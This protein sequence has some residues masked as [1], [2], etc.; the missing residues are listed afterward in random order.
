MMQHDQLAQL[1]KDQFEEFIAV[2]PPQRLHPR[3]IHVSNKAPP[4]DSYKINFYGAIF[5][6]KNQSGIGGVVH[7]SEGLVIAS[8]SQQLP[9]AFQSLE[10]EAIVT[11]RAL[12]FGIE[13]EVHQAILEGDSAVIMK[14][15]MPQ[16]D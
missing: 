14:A 15:M 12:E 1:S 9:Q 5:P 7:N 11:S 4:M 10:I 8:L 13:V 2:H 3:R 6:R 16:F